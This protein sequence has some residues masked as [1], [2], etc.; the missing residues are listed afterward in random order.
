[1]LERRAVQVSD[2]QANPEYEFKEAAK[3]GGANTMLGVPLL[4]EGSP[5]G[6]MVLQRH[7]LLPFTEKQIEIHAR[8]CLELSMSALGGGLN[9]SL[10]HRL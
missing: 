5:I 3:V 4:R 1:M 10:Q 9:R 7:A 8:E 6:V 2:V